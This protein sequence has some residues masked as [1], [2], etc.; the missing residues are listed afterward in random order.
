MAEK[1]NPDSIIPMP[2]WQRLVFIGLVLGVLVLALFM[3]RAPLLRWA[4]AS[5]GEH[6]SLDEANK[7]DLQLELPPE[8]SDIRFY[9][10]LEPD[11]VVIID[12]A[13]SEEGFMKWAKRQGWT[14]EKVRGSITIHPRASFG[15]RST[16]VEVKDGYSHHNLV[17]GEPNT[18]SVVF[19]RPSGRAFYQFHSEPIQAGE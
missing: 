10:H 18:F 1:S 8:A 14:P 5:S 7:Y 13:I 2:H 12:F 15:D 9:Q 16:K 17:P 6:L 11:Q 19:D 3:A 4:T